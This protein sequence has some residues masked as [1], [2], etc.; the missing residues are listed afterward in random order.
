[1]KKNCGQSFSVACD[2]FETYIYGRDVVNVETDHKP[3]ESIVLK[4][5]HSAPK[6]LQRMLLKLQ[7]YNLQIKYKKGQEMFLAD[8]L[9]RA[10]LSEVN[11]CDFTC[12]L[13]KVDHKA[14]LAVS[15]A[16]WQQISHASA[17]DPVLQQLRTTIQQGWPKTRSE[18]PECLYPYFDSRDELTVQDDLVF[19]CQRLVVPAVLRKE[20]MPVAHATHIGI[21]G[22]ICRARNTLYWPRMATELKEYI[23]K[24]DIC[25]AHRSAQPKEPLL[26]H[27]VV[28]LPWPKVAAD[29]CELHN[30]TILV[31][32]DYYSTQLHRSHPPEHS[33]IAKCHQGDKS[34]V[35]QIR[36]PRRF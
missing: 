20:L 33:D 32:S 6:R 2:R 1:M 24:C 18:I 9:S 21:E 26:Q 5:L 25:L 19:K 11:A 15:D 30:R 27:E 17:D 14:S 13:E 23:S 8:T 4:P 36:H 22:C 10:F 34:C 12:E 35:C 3:L 28:A 31:I 16:R 29:L 7:K